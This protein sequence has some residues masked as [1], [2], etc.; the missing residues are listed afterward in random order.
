MSVIQFVHTLEKQPTFN[1]LPFSVRSVPRLPAAGS[2]RCLILH[3]HKGA[4]V[5]HN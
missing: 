3:S 1:I 4:D 2:H 5:L